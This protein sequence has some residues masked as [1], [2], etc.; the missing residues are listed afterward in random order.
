VRLQ[1]FDREVT[2][3]HAQPGV[4][5]IGEWCAWLV[6]ASYGVYLVAVAASGVLTGS[7]PRD[8]AWAVAEVV[9]VV[10]APIQV[11]FFAAIYESAPARARIFGLLGFAFMVV[12][13]ALT[14]SVHFVELTVARRADLGADSALVHIFSYTQPSLLLGIEFLAWHLFFGLSILLT[15]FAFSPRGKELWVRIGLAGAGVLCIAGLSGPILDRPALR[16][17]GVIGYGIV[18]P[19]AAF[20]IGL[21]FRSARRQAE[22]RVAETSAGADVMPA[23]GV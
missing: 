8:P 10:F 12:M 7:V 22:G 21:V 19:V 9:I 16:T 13:A 14:V 17:I 3:L 18:F 11:I 20:V 6:V 1:E 5:R 23:L 2:G 15:A 4:L